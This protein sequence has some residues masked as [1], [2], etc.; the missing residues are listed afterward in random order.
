MLPKR[1]VAF[2]SSSLYGRVDPEGGGYIGRL[3]RWHESEDI[4]NAVFNLG[5]SG[6]TTTGILKRL[7]SEASVRRPNLILI[8]TGL[9][10]TRRVG[11]KNASITTPVK[12]FKKNVEELITQARSL[13]KVIFISVYP[14]DD[15][16]TTPLIGTDYYYLLKDAKEYAKITKRICK[17]GR[18]PY[19]DIFNEWLKIDYLPYLYEDGLHANARGHQE[20]FHRLKNFLGELYK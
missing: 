14:I 17:S 4:H 11:S 1:I 8:T 9:N 13:A 5:I 6:D 12:Q 15:R 2:G 18:I 7:V 10:D 19:L 3:R 20:I 16:R